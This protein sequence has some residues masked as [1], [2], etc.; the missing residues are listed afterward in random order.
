MLGNIISVDHTLKPYHRQ[1]AQFQNGRTYI[2]F[3]DLG[4]FNS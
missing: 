3:R 4:D 2:C 1:I